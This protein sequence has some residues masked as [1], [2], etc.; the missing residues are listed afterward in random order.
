LE[1]KFEDAVDFM[2]A[3]ET[4]YSKAYKVQDY[5]GLVDIGN[6][7]ALIFG[8]EPMLT[9]ILN[10]TDRKVIAARWVYADDENF[11]DQILKGLD[12][13][14]IENWQLSLTFNLSRK[15]ISI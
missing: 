15:T 12:T 11:V 10:T 6:D 1:N 4:D 14:K 2:D 3:E 13:T 5:L 7:F 9:T 8:D